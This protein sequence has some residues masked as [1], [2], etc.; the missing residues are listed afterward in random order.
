MTGTTTYQ[1][2]PIEK[3][4]GF[5]LVLLNPSSD[6][7]SPL[8]GS[9][10]NTTLSDCD[11][12]LIEP[13][14][15]LSYVWGAPNPKTNGTIILDLIHHMP[16]GA[17][18]DAALR[19]LRDA[20][21]IRRVW[22]DALCIDQQNI[23]ERNKQVTMMGRIYTTANHTVIHLGSL[24]EEA[25]SVL[26]AVP[27]QYLYFLGVGKSRPRDE[28]AIV[29][30]AKR[31]ILT[32]PWF[33]RVWIYQELILSKDPWVQLGKVRV[34]WTDLCMFLVGPPTWNNMSSRE[35]DDGLK[36]LG[37][38]NWARANGISGSAGTLLD[39]LEQRRGLG[40]TDPRDFVYAH[41]GLAQDQ[42]KVSRFVQVNYNK[43][44][45]EVYGDVARYVLHNDERGSALGTLLKGAED[46]KQD[47]ELPSW[48]PDWRFKVPPRPEM[49]KDKFW[50]RTVFT[51][52]AHWAI[53]ESP[54]QILGILGYHV[55]QI[56][57]VGTMLPPCSTVDREM[58][59]GCKNAMSA[60][61]AL[62]QSKGGIYYS[63]D[64]FGQYP[65]APLRG[66]EADHQSLCEALAG[67]WVKFLR[68]LESN[69]SETPENGHRHFEFYN[70]LGDWLHHEAT[71]KRIFVGQ[72]SHGLLRIM[73]DYIHG[74]SSSLDGR[75]L[76]RMTGGSYGVIPAT[77]N[78]GH[79]IV[80][81]VG[82]DWPVVLRGLTPVPEGVRE[83]F[84]VSVK[85]AL[86]QRFPAGNLVYHGGPQWLPLDDTEAPIDHYQ[87]VGACCVDGHVGW[88][89]LQLP[90]KEEMHI[91]GLH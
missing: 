79:V 57:E 29:E 85:S 43:S 25:K 1:Y 8:H 9:L 34:R 63:G 81:L 19:D 49:W 60:I 84:D 2:M 24:T 55:D 10:L 82:C 64:G 59:A 45:A 74:V 56:D 78:R 12:D 40:A 26:T 54:R 69:G 18:L 23:P 89:L 48:L 58:M 77:A 61:S 53:V 15:A 21:R 72:D 50:S 52:P 62:Y 30:L 27:R 11:F 75:R 41:L 42:N 44:V 20:S 38:M 17:S 16:I 65:H 86:S 36:L 76:A 87:V 66:K 80:G 7:T 33:R 3:A 5:R 28:N 88:G 70:E 39:L 71:K 90:A 46:S 47:G 73:N 83:Q 6:P 13:W 68:A 31:D 14:T 4:D 32:R 22:A 51:Q 37:N 67:E 35:L 91:F